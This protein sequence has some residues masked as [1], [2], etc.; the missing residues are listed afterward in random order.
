LLAVIHARLENREFDKTLSRKM[1]EEL[2]HA[3]YASL[4]RFATQYLNDR[5][6][7]E[8]IVQEVFVNLWQKRDSIDPAKQVKTYLF[9]AVR[10]RCLNFIRDRKKFRSF[11]LDVEVELEFPVQERDLLTGAEEMEMI[12]KALDKLP[13]K[14]RAVFELSRF[15]NMR[16]HEIASHLNI[17]VKTV[18]AQVS[19]ALK[20]LREEL[21]DLLWAIIL[22]LLQ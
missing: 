21:K 7:S 10:N 20:I 11:Y 2:F 14:C 9:T 19:K 5:S 6:D 22:L 15:D 18:E 16:Y 17:S 3:H 1:F 8:E 13:E 12:G 4:C